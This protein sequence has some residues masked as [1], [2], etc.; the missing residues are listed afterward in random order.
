MQSAV[1]V[2]DKSNALQ[3]FLALPA[4]PGSCSLLTVQLGFWNSSTPPAALVLLW[5]LT[6]SL[7]LSD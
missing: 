4:S 2:V 1:Q 3:P 6:Q 7:Q 5:S